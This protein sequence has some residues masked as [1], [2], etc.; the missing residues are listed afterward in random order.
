M[1]WSSSEAAE[2]FSTKPDPPARKASAAR[3]GSSFTVKKITLTSGIERMSCRAASRPLS[4]GMAMSSTTTSGRSFGAAS[5]SARPSATAPTTSHSGSS[6]LTNASRS[7]RWSSASKTR[8]RF[9]SGSCLRCASAQRNTDADPR[10]VRRFRVDGELAP[11][12]EHA[13]AHADESQPA[14]ANGQGVVEAGAVVDDT[15]S[16]R[17]GGPAQLDASVLRAAVLD[18]VRQR[19][20]R[21]AIEAQRDLRRNRWRDLIRRE[22]DLEAM[23]IGQLVA[24]ARDRRREP[25]LLQLRRVELMR[26]LVYRRRQLPHLAQEIPYA[27]AEL[28]HGLRGLLA[29]Q[30][31][32][33]RQQR[34][35]L[36]EVVVELARDP[37]RFVLLRLEQPASQLAKLGLAQPQI[38]FRLPAVPHLNEQGHDQRRLENEERSGADDVPA[39]QIPEPWLAV[40]HNGRGGQSRLAEAP[41]PQLSPIHHVLVRA[42]G[43]SRDRLRALSGENPQ[44]QAR[45]VPP[46]PLEAHDVTT[47]D[48]APDVRAHVTVDRSVGL[49]GKQ[50]ERLGRNERLSGGVLEDVQILDDALIGQVGDSLQEII[51]RQPAQVD[52]LDSLLVCLEPLPRDTLPVLVEARVARDDEHA[53]GPRLQA[54]RQLERS[55]QVH[56]DRAT[57]HVGRKRALANFLRVQRGVYDG[58]TGKDRLAILERKVERWREAGHDQ[59][60]LLARV[61]L[62]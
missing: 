1:A 12:R 6:S 29:Q 2:F 58:D 38:P 15:Q 52:E 26:E 8:G 11:E 18:G 56:L 17:V 39:V 24:Q 61:F 59:V 37:P 3:S 27:G 33:D 13:L 4:W 47:H 45:R 30:I 35:P 9:T 46:R 54:E 41:A 36:A 16:D 40:T 48:S 20:L 43:G 32:L 62:P 55:D 5:S 49:S 51:H 44:T 31:H 22:L 14:L 34:Q 53:P 28:A 21:D 60:D 25:E 42:G 10:T 23:A 7:N 19:L 57:D 50:L